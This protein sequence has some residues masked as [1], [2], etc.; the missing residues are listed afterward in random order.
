MKKLILSSFALFLAISAFS[1]QGKVISAFNYMQSY[2]APEGI[3]KTGDPKN[4]EEA[5][6]NID[7]AVADPS[8]QNSSKAWWY[9]SNIYQLI[10]SVIGDT[11]I[12]HN[13]PKASLE[14]AHSFQKLV[15]I[16]DPK[17]REWKDAYQNMSAICSNLF[18]DGVS[19]YQKKNFHDAYI[20]FSTVGD[21]QDLLAAKGQKRDTGLLNKALG[22]A[23]LSAETDNDYATAIALYKKMALKATD[24][25]PYVVLVST[26]KKARDIEAA[27]K[28]T[29]SSIKFN[30]EAKKYTD[31]GLAKY[32]NESQL[33]IDKINFYISDGKSGEGINYIQKALILDPKNEQLYTAL[34]MAY[35]EIGDTT[36]AR[37]TYLTL[38]DLNPNGFDGNFHIGAMI[39]NS[40]KPIQLLMNNLGVTKADLKKNDELQAQRDALFLQAKVYFEKAF[41]AKPDN[42]EVKKALNIIEAK[43]KK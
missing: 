4:L 25:K 35:E 20:F 13:Y 34:G 26:I 9:R 6:K 36:N 15:E 30:D 18:N 17:F 33:L 23:G 42:A 16:N 10:A 39:F 12:H 31:E 2:N 27:K 40:T 7:I 24:A 29:V 22:N 41:A 19:A 11:M 3:S 14:A 8:T 28:D 5:A 1:Q 43:T 37:K 38:L 32:P 21:V